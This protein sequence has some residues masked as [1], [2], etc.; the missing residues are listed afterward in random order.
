MK[1]IVQL[2]LLCCALT[3]SIALA[4][5]PN[6]AGSLYVPAWGGSTATQG[7]VFRFNASNGEFEEVVIGPL[8]IDIIPGMTLGPDRHL[9]LSVLDTQNNQNGRVLRYDLKGRSR[10][11]FIVPGSGG[12]EFP[13]GLRFGL[14]G[15][16]YVTSNSPAIDKLLRFDR[17]GRFAGV[18]ATNLITPQDVVVAPDGS[19]LVSNGNSFASSIYSYDPVTDG[20]VG[21][22]V[23]SGSGGLQNPT[24]MAFGPDGH[25]YVISFPTNSVFKFDGASGAFV[26]IFASLDGIGIDTPTDLVFGPDGNLYVL[27]RIGG[28]GTVVRLDGNKGTFIDFF[29]DGA[30]ASMG[31]GNT[32]MLFISINS[33]YVIPAQGR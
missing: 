14:D 21:A 4:K 9:Y 17:R 1:T 25:L 19:L 23:P 27:A 22:F 6:A 32:G 5:P 12:L 33:V 13:A 26:S 10:G 3:A 15:L 7:S 20:F 11:E 8:G 18:V 28:D 16:L 29:V 31:I 24:G 2:F 30:S